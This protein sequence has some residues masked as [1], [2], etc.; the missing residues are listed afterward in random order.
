M[1]GLLN[2]CHNYRTEGY[3][4]PIKPFLFENLD[5]FGNPIV[6]LRPRSK[7]RN[8]SE[9]NHNSAATG[10]GIGGVLGGYWGVLPRGIG[11]VLGM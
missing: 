2:T 4:I 8:A 5:L 3:Q 9:A 11:G 7:N 10:W 1:K 6:T